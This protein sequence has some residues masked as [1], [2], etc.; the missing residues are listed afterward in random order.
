MNLQDKKI[1][2]AEKLFL[3]WFEVESCKLATTGRAARLQLPSASGQYIE[4]IL[5]N[6]KNRPLVLELT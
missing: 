6:L 5:L 2:V 1:L 3:E 4:Y